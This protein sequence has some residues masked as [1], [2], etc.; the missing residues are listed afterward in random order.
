MS[1]EILKQPAQFPDHPVQAMLS[2]PAGQLEASLGV[3][4]PAPAQAVAVICHSISADRGTLHNKVVHMME[5]SLR[6][7][8]A[9]TIR[10]NF[11]GVGDSDGEFDRGFGESEDLLAVCQWA[12]QVLPDLPLWIAGY[13]FGA[14]VTARCAPSIRP[15]QLIS[16]SPLLDQFDFSTLPRAQCPWLIVQGD[17]DECVNPDSVYQWANGLEGET[18]LI[19]MLDVNHSYHRRLMDLRGVLKNGVRRQLD[20]A[21]K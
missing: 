10:F 20:P 7:L 9:H 21:A 3:A 14:F 2:G 15:Q 6:E 5:R 1:S 13:G 11:R 19:S 16:V 17:E 12:R 4:E 8:S 18:Q